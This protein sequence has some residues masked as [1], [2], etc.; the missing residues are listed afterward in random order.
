MTMMAMHPH[1]DR[2]SYTLLCISVLLACLLACCHSSRLIDGCLS[3]IV[4][5]TSLA[6]GCLAT[7]VGTTTVAAVQNAACTV[8]V[9]MPLCF[10]CSLLSWWCYCHPPASICLLSHLSSSH[11]LLLTSLLLCSNNNAAMPKSLAAPMMTLLCIT[12]CII[13]CT[14]ACSSCCCWFTVAIFSKFFLDSMALHGWQ[15]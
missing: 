9:R 3:K 4:L 5:T 11:F 1:N 12:F 10:A 8:L 6:A 13:A 7:A 15:H 2:A 14:A